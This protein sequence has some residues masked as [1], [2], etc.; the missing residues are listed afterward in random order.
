MP[1]T[2]HRVAVVGVVS[3]VV[4][5][6]ALTLLKLRFDVDEMPMWL[7][8]GCSL[9]ELGAGL[10]IIG[11]ALQES[12]PGRALSKGTVIGAAIAA[13]GIQV[14]V[15]FTTWQFAPGMPI[16]EDAVGAGMSC[17]RHDTTLGLPALAITFWLVL[18]ALP[19]RPSIAGLLGGAGAGLTA[20]AVTHL[21][22]PVSDLNHV[23][24]WHTGAIVLLMTFG[25]LVGKSWEWYRWRL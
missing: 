16:P 13:A 15:G 14:L 21:L 6:A 8:W 5:A 23:L 11:L 19:L 12:I 17:L 4:L 1:P 3:F 20:D 24:V 9:L 25:W 22:C 7:S 2:W 18:R 10:G